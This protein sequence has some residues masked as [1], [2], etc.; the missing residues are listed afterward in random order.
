MFVQK[1]TNRLAVGD[2]IAQ[3]D[4]VYTNWF[5][6]NIKTKQSTWTKPEAL[7]HI[8]FKIPSDLNDDAYQIP[9]NNVQLTTLPQVKI[10]KFQHVRNKP[11]QSQANQRVF[12][13][14]SDGEFFGL[15]TTIFRTDGLVGGLYKKLA[16][17]YDNTAK[18]TSV[19][20]L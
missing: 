19:H 3:F 8:S 10:Q 2:W 13:E 15:N 9:P 7:G 4:E 11:V 14:S 6:Y 5:Y 12:V 18:V 17:Y 16:N 20:D 1:S